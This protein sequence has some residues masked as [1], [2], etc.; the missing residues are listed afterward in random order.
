M[1]YEIDLGLEIE[2][3]V[4]KQKLP[5]VPESYLIIKDGIV[6]GLR[7]SGLDQDEELAE[8]IYNIFN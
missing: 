5:N 2:L 7:Y 6:S 8:S 1:Q 4:F 3:G